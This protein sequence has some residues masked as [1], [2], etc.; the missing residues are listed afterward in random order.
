MCDL[1]IQAALWFCLLLAAAVPAQAQ[2]SRL[3]GGYAGRAPATVTGDE[4]GRQTNLWVLE[5]DFK[6][7]RMIPVEVTDPRTGKKARE[8]I[9]YMAY[10]AINRPV[11]RRA[12]ET[13]TEPQNDYDVQPQRPLFVP[14]FTLLTSVTE[15]GPT[16]ILRDTII[17]EA[18]PLIRARE[19]R[20]LKN[21][22]SVV[23]EIP[24]VTPVGAAAE[25]V[26]YGVAIWRGVDPETD[27]FTVF[28]SGFSNGYRVTRGPDDKPLIERRIVMQ[29]F[30]RPGDRFDQQ[31]V[32]IR[33]KGDPTWLYVAD[34]P[35]QLA[36]AQPQ[37]P[38]ES[39]PPAE[40]P[41]QP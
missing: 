35:K 18:E 25:D 37:Q 29:E 12:D 26:I 40:E 2:S 4:L 30:W 8:W 11:E 31:E 3:T 1:K 28:M 7:M 21:S 6:P 15:G 10:R 19:K 39:E 23:R 38:A 9:W 27:F 41:Q 32:E 20:E 36:A 22:V 17:P 14:E 34:E 24:E 5:V 16:E 13:D 33:L